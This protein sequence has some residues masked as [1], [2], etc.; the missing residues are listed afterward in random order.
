[1]T[2]THHAEDASLASSEAATVPHRWRNLL[3]LTGVTVVDNTEGSVTTT[4]F[5]TI[6]AA[7]GLTTAGLGVLTATGKVASV[8]AGPAWMWLA[9]RI[10]RKRTLIATTLAGGVFGIL[11]GFSQG[12]GMLLLF[13]TL[14][15]ASIIGGSPIANAVIADSFEDKV[16][17]KAAGTFYAIVN[18]V[19]S[20]IGP[21]IAL[22]TKMEGGWRYAMW[23]IGGICLLA[24]LLVVVGFKDPGIGAAEKELADLDE[25]ERVTP[26]VSVASVLSLFRI[27][28]YAVMMLS[29]LLSG[30][31]LIGV[32][33][34]V[35]LVSERGFTNATAALVG[36]PF[37]L[38]YVVGTLTGGFTVSWLDKVMPRRGRP[39]FIQFAQ[40][41][42]A[43]VAFF[44]TQFPHGNDIA[45]YGVFWALMG[46]CQGFNVPVN[47]PIVTAVIL[48]E[49][50]GQ[51]FAIWLTIFET[52]GWALFSLVA[53]SLAATLGIQTVFLWVLVI[54]MF[55]NAAV[56]T[57]LY[58]TYP[59]DVDKV[60]A[61]LLARREAAIG[62]E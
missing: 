24:S 4:L 38:G 18:G 25:N 57:I 45:V 56:L 22:F 7:L 62:A 36:I 27:P 35:F 60:S 5:P 40:I 26:K 23:T 54:L 13:N 30:H 44:A 6:A 52:I 61:E 12:F 11:A 10:G 55:V 15:V 49:L 42:F 50:R 33:G 20:F 8:P 29:R 53:G 14:M 19:A 43:V 2:T 51:G 28:T 31:L 1:M 9:G 16:R 37:G 59:K 32:F 46:I 17:A 58:V 21:A 39:M 41:A 3:T 34:I 48:P 47:R